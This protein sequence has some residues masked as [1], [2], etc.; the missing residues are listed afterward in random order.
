[1]K[2][3]FLI[4]SE[5]RQTGKTYLAEMIGGSLGRANYIHASTMTN[6]YN[7]NTLD[8]NVL[9]IEL[10][11]FD[12]PAEMNAIINFVNQDYIERNH[13]REENVIT[14]TPHMILTGTNLDDFAEQIVD[15]K[16]LKVF[17]INLK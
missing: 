5:K 12:T 4:S 1:M 6:I 13:P 9:I 16:S 3:V 14:K 17:S 2:K 8:C 11:K 15:R 7:A 10:S